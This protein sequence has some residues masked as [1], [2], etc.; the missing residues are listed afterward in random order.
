MA[1]KRLSIRQ[2]APTRAPTTTTVHKGSEHDSEFKSSFASEQPYK[3]E[4]GNNNNF[5][6]EWRRM[7]DGG[8]VV[9]LALYDKSFH[10]LAALWTLTSM[11]VRYT[12]AQKNGATR[13]GYK[14]VNRTK[15][16][17]AGV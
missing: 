11:Y 2:V 16:R 6:L 15:Y 17:L 5:I 7:K 10:A 4:Q 14:F 3:S 1:G 12:G 13:N 9:H 8:R